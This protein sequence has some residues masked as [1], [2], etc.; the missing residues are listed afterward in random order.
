MT[1][2][3][4]ALVLSLIEDRGL[5]LYLHRYYLVLLNSNSNAS[6]FLSLLLDTLKKFDSFCFMLAAL[7]YSL[8]IILLVLRVFDFFVVADF[9]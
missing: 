5:L 9:G 3:R 8:S 2:S 1:T 7:S 6:F 4:L